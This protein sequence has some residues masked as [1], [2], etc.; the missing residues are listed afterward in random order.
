MASTRFRLGDRYNIEDYT[1][2]KHIAPCKAGVDFSHQIT[3]LLGADKILCLPGKDLDFVP[4]PITI[5]LGDA[6]V[7]G[8][9]PNLPPCRKIE[10]FSDCNKKFITT[11]IIN[12]G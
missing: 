1:E 11:Y 12:I 7:G 9:L 5:G 4:H 6:F 8:M 3:D 2:T 10:R